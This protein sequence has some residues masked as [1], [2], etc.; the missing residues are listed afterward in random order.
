MRSIVLLSS[1][2]LA[3]TIIA[4]APATLTLD[5]AR[6]A[7]LAHHPAGRDG[8]LYMEAGELAAKN[9]GSAW[10]PQVVATGRATYQSEVTEF[11]LGAFGLPP[12]TISRDQYQA[13]LE[14]RQTLCEFGEDHTRREIA[15]N[16][17]RMQT[18]QADV[19]LLQVRAA[20]DHLY[21]NILLQRENLR[22]LHGRAVEIAAR[23]AK[24]ESAVRNGVSLRSNAEVLRAEAVATHEKILDA[25]TALVQT[26]TSLGVLMGVPVDTTTTFVLP[27]SPPQERDTADQRPER[28]VFAR[29]GQGLDLGGSLVRRRNLPH[30]MAFADGYYGRPGFDFLNNDL[31]PYGLVGVGFNWNIAGFYTQGRE[32]H[33]LRVMQQVVDGQRERF[34]LRQRSDL[35][36]QDLEIAKLDRLIEMDRDIVESRRTIRETA[37]SQLENGVITAQ[38]YVGY[39]NAQD[40]AMLDLELHRIQA[41]MAR[42]DRERILGR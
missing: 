36:R 42:I 41:V 5:Q 25:E 4:Q 19:E 12:I 24:V 28:E 10:L 34:E 16:D 26:V 18:A 7:A 38:D 17:A 39:Q 30:L 14:V 20:V 23:Q 31:R 33:R 13:G 9:A 11:D 27:A 40:Q 21:G 22:I 1:L 6:T 35:E 29:K 3:G 32:L 15:L 8:A 37:A 2:C